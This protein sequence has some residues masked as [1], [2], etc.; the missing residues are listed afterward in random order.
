MANKL[1]HRDVWF[2][3]R[4]VRQLAKLDGRRPLEYSHHATKACQSDRYG[5]I[6]QLRSLDMTN[7]EVVEVEEKNKQIVKL[8]GR[9]KFSENLDIVLAI[10]PR[11]GIMF[12]K[13]CWLNKTDD[14]HKTLRV[15]QYESKPK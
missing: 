15:N 9:I 3:G 13:T 11:R 2:P 1:F 7:F 6:P 12:V 5:R 8:V 10:M 4:I 14:D